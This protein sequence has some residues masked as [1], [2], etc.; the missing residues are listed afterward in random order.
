MVT[1]HLKFQMTNTKSQIIS[2]I[3]IQKSKTEIRLNKYIAVCNKIDLETDSFEI[4]L[5]EIEIYLFFVF[6]GL[7]LG[8]GNLEFVLFVS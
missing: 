1:F 8:I 3:K 5:L 2:N 7:G 4:C 6:G